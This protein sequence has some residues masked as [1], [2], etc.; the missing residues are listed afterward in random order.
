MRR[1]QLAVTAVAVS[2]ALMLAGCTGGDSG[3]ESGTLTIWTIEDVADRV[4]AQE[5]MYARFTEQTGIEI[6]FV[7]VSEDQLTTVLTSAAASDDLPDAIGAIDL[8]SVYNFNNDG[9]LDTDAAAAVIDALGADTFSQRALELVTSEGEPLAVPSDGWAQL[10]YYRA[11]LFEAAG[12]EPPTTFDQIEAAAAALDSDSLAG[13]TLATAPGDTFTQ[14]TFEHFALANGCELVSDD[15]EVTIDTP[16][17]VGALEFVRDL[18]A[19]YSVA[20]NQDVDT[21]R[22]TYFA[23]GAAMVVWSSFL[24]DELAGLRNDALPTCPECE[25]D[26]GFLAANTGVVSAIQGPD[27]EEPASFGA[28][29][30]WVI[31]DGASPDT[32]GFVE[33]MMSESYVDW[34][35]IAPEGKVPTRFG[36]ADNPTEYSDAWNALEAGVDTK[37]ALSSIYPAEVLEAVVEAPNGFSMWG[38]PQGQ[39]PLAG[40]VAGQLVFPRIISDMLNSDLSPQDAAERGQDEVVTI[41]EDLGF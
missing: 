36:T 11:D 19:N 40:A 31:L 33:W 20:G 37:A 6:E 35:G 14:Q 23:G 2:S 24:L 39:G 8:T 13:I 29:T 3:Q 27:A 1:Q 18:A 28:I 26:P 15:G 7:P 21:T 17:C 22:A 16:E 30:S 32:T 25:A 41:Q 12:L 5:A 4:T 10:L 38:I 34:L 9:L